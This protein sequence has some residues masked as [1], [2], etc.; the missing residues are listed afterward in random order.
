MPRHN[1]SAAVVALGFSVVAAC[2]TGPQAQ[3]ENADQS[4]ALLVEKGI[5]PQMVEYLGQILSSVVAQAAMMDLAEQRT[6]SPM[7]SDA[8][9]F[10]K[11][12]ND[13]LQDDIAKFAKQEGL[14]LPASAGPTNDLRIGELTSLFGS[15]FDHKYLK[16]QSQNLQTSAQHAQAASSVATN[17]NYIAFFTDLVKF[18]ED[19]YDIYQYVEKGHGGSADLPGSLTG[20]LGRHVIAA[21]LGRRQY[22]T[23]RGRAR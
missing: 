8:T 10:Y 16:Y 1:R 19:A 6:K 13:Q 23:L 4:D 20:L 2:G 5:S 3:L 22:D 21:Q 15:W 18:L 14:F 7:I 12:K 11:G 9:Q 17:P